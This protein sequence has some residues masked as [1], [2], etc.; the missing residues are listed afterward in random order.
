MGVL[1]KTEKPVDKIS[2]PENLYED[3][4]QI[5]SFFNNQD[6]HIGN[7]LALQS[8]DNYMLVKTVIAQ[9]FQSGL[10]DALK[11]RPDIA[12][13]VVNEI[14]ERSLSAISHL[15]AGSIELIHF[16]LGADLN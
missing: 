5:E 12:I 1:F 15:N 3:L 10:T 11:E 14:V 6:T 13:D 8:L 4:K 2:V 9:Y 7:S 16:I